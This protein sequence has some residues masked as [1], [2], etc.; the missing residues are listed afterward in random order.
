[1]IKRLEFN[2]PVRI[3]CPTC[4]S[5]YAGEFGKR[6]TWKLEHTSHL[7]GGKFVITIV[8][9]EAVQED[10]DLLVCP[11]VPDYWEMRAN[12]DNGE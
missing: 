10:E 5:V 4:A 8:K 6:D 1:M 3:T 12:M 11:D 7:S 2:Q 9:R